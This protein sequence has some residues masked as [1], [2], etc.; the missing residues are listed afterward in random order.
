MDV[1]KVRAHGSGPAQRLGSLTFRRIEPTAFVHHTVS[2][3]HLWGEHIMRTPGI[4]AF[5][6]NI[7]TSD[8]DSAWV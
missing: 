6:K 7:R 4:S 3:T 2:T 5:T 8:D 1:L